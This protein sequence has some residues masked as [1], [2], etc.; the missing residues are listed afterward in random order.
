MDTKFVYN[1]ETSQKLTDE[2]VEKL[3]EMLNEFWQLEKLNEM[4]NEF[5]MN[6]EEDE[7]VPEWT[8]EI[9]LQK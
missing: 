7:L 6:E 9:E 4:L 3:N 8:T 2:Q 1:F 5:W